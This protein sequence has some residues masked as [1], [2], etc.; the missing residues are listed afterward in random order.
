MPLIEK[1]MAA[2]TSLPLILF[3]IGIMACKPDENPFPKATD[4][5]PTDNAM[6]DK[7]IGGTIKIRVGS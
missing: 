3:V 5:Q 7:P 2:C 1:K 6:S 4:T